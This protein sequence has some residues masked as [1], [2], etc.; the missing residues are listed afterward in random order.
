MQPD[1][2]DLLFALIHRTPF[3]L[4]DVRVFRRNIINTISVYGFRTRNGMKGQ[5]DAYAFARGGG[6]IEIETKAAR[7]AMRKEQEAWRAFCLSFGIPHL[8]LRALPN[9]TQENT[10]S[11]WIDDLGRALLKD[12]AA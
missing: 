5:A 3:V 6:Y 4:P 11:R 1:E 9:E 10:V 7:G 2:T 8:V 12:R